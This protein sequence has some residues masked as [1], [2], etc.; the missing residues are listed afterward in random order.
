M[1]ND[2]I[3]LVANRLLRLFEKH[4]KTLAKV[5]KGIAPSEIF[6]SFGEWVS[7]WA[8]PV[9]FV[10]MRAAADARCRMVADSIAILAQDSSN[11]KH[12]PGLVSVAA[13]FIDTHVPLVVAE[14]EPKTVF[15]VYRQRLAPEEHG[16]FP[17]AIGPPFPPP[18]QNVGRALANAWTGSD[19][20]GQHASR[21]RAMPRKGNVCGKGVNPATALTKL[22]RKCARP[23]ASIRYINPQADRCVESG[24]VERDA[25]RDIITAGLLGAY[26]DATDAE[27]VWT[28]ERRAAMYASTDTDP[29]LRQVIASMT[30][31]RLFAVVSRYLRC[32]TM[33]F[34]A[35]WR[36]SQCLS[37]DEPMI[38]VP[39]NRPKS[40]S[41]GRR[42]PRP[43]ATSKIS[44]SITVACTPK[45]LSAALLAKSVQAAKRELPASAPPNSASVL[46]AHAARHRAAFYVA[47]L[48]ADVA[49]QQRRAVCAHTGL[50]TVQVAICRMCT[51]IHSKVKGA[52]QPVKKRSG[53]T[54]MISDDGVMRPGQCA[55][56]GCGDDAV[57]IVDAVGKEIRARV[58]HSDPDATTIMICTE[59]GALCANTVNVNGTFP[60]CRPCAAA[61]HNAPW[62]SIQ[63]QHVGYTQRLCPCGAAATTGASAAASNG[64]G[65]PPHVCVLCPGSKQGT[66]RLPVCSRHAK[67]AAMLPATYVNT[68]QWFRDLF[69]SKTAGGK[70]GRGRRGQA[71][72]K[73]GAAHLGIRRRQRVY[74]G[75]GAASKL[76]G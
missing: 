53:I 41:G 45:E 4:R 15:A 61:R 22:L 27:I 65:P 67:I 14:P 11:T 12:L 23:P 35:I 42:K 55:A 56:C 21:R 18:C 29:K 76:F 39:R 10:S 48:S 47:E 1:N 6:A 24:G 58:R 60:A 63:E 3:I 40:T 30:T 44:S 50:T 16:T 51:T 75:R 25:M 66:R 8:G 52:A 32:A 46:V 54:M 7:A 37:H 2:T 57:I 17:V 43:A 28:L 62:G 19:P 5:L 74:C 64:I 13:F 31:K 38:T 36:A 68:V 69:L 34:P 9:E 26:V 71:G 20:V 70:R 59:C 72:K 49:A 33:Q 73:H